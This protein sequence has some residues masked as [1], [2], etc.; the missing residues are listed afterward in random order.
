MKKFL[1]LF[2][3]LVICGSVFAYQNTY[4]LSSDEVQTFL[5]LRKASSS[6]TVDP[7]FPISASQLAELV[8]SL[9][10]SKL[11]GKYLEMY[12]N[13]LDSLETPK[14]LF[15]RN[16]GGYDVNVDLLGCQLYGAMKSEK[17]EIL[18][19][20]DRLPFADFVND[21][22]FK[23]YFFGR[24]NLNISS[25]ITDFNEKQNLITLLNVMKFSD[26]Y[27]NN[28]YASFGFDNLSFIIGRDR[29][30]VGNGYTGNL[31]LG[32]NTFFDDFA[33]LSFINDFISYDF[34]ITSFN[35]D[36]KGSE[37]RGIH[38][39]SELDGMK[40][41]VFI[42]RISFNIADKVSVSAYEGALFY[43]KSIFQDIKYF[44]PFMFMH[45]T[46]TYWD[47]STN[48]FFGLE[49]TAAL[50]KNYQLNFQFFLDQICVPGI[51]V[52][53]SLSG[54]MAY[55]ALI[56]VSSTKQIGSG[57][58]DY[59]FEGVYGNPYVYLKNKH[60]YG[61]SYDTTKEYEG[62]QDS[63]DNTNFDLVFDSY[64]DL[65]RRGSVN[66]QYMG[67]KYGGDVLC[68]STGA[69]YTISTFK[70]TGALEFISKGIYGIN[71]ESGEKRLAQDA[72]Q[73]KQNTFKASLGANIK[74]Y[75]GLFISAKGC[76]FHNINDKHVE[77]QN[78]TDI[79]LSIGV[80]VKPLD[81]FD[82]KKPL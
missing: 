41:N 23:D 62:K 4:R 45:N 14:V 21:F 46:D 40:K 56:N 66:K 27:P 32:E 28:S 70:F 9:D 80:H 68:I 60:T 31:E 52:Q 48:N 26:G 39:D 11:S 12:Q 51:E 69:S 50:K 13:L 63:Y 30:G 64:T 24:F 73:I 77:G 74:L 2:L 55:A 29:L 25:L 67:Y 17:P 37:E 58:L 36:S 7:T 47:A 8:K 18:P 19:Y 65:N 42:H 35:H 20:K 82:I 38:A 81:F 43:A 34:T 5:L 71:D 44:N 57:I 61:V 53:E 76:A 3:V 79:Q 78:L 22:Y 49:T 6:I 75:D 59:Y 72:Q 10:S 33:K 54:E 1:C 15:G 16:G